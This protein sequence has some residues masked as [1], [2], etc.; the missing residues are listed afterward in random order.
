MTKFDKTS[1]YQIYLTKSDI[2]IG[3]QNHG[4]GSRSNISDLGQTYPMY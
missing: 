3:L 1:L 4:T 2:V